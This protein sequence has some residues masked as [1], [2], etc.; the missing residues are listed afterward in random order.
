MTE[1]TPFAFSKLFSD[2]TDRQVTF[3]RLPGCPPSK[4]LTLYGTYVVLPAEHTIVI[5]ADVPAMACLAGAL[6]GMPADTAIEHALETPMDESVRDAMHEVLNIASTAL[7][8]DARV[9]FKG[10]TTNRKELAL[11]AEF[12]VEKPTGKP[13]Y[14]VTVDGEAHG[15]FT[16]LSRH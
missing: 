16:I 10:F 9:V 13:T 5:K 12:A 14:K 7:S 8:T 6:L 1:P 11:N 4:A 15:L 2:L 3:A